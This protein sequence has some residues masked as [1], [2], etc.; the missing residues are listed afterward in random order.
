[1]KH[2]PTFSSG[3]VY[4]D[5][6]PKHEL[7]VLITAQN[8]R[9]PQKYK[10]NF[11]EFSEW[12]SPE[13][14]RYRF[15]RLNNQSITQNEDKKNKD[16]QDEKVKK[17][18]LQG[19]DSLVNID[20]ETLTHNAVNLQKEDEDDRELV[21]SPSKS[22]Q[23]EALKNVLERLDGALQCFNTDALPGNAK[24]LVADDFYDLYVKRNYPVFGTAILDEFLETM[25]KKIVCFSQVIEN[26]RN[27][28]DREMP[29]RIGRKKETIS[30]AFQASV[31]DW[32]VARKVIK[33]DAKKLTL[34]ILQKCGEIDKK[35]Q[36]STVRRSANKV[37][38]SA[39][40]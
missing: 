34:A 13:L 2:L 10:I 37:Q 21:G 28:I 38:I 36:V 23:L 25:V 4:D 17:F 27:Q 31:I 35:T 19:I 16:R 7:E 14:G 24:A 12:F 15:D 22:E 30:S 18:K 5:R 33:A 6:I 9:Q 40:K 3:G 29:G 26:A 32:F 20:G 39:E 11:D 1:M 8:Q